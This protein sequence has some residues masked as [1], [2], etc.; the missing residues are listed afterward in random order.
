MSRICG[1]VENRNFAEWHCTANLGR[2]A[3]CEAVGCNGETCP[4]QTF[5]MHDC[6]KCGKTWAMTLLDG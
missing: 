4:N 2:C 1:R 6:L 3:H 5:H